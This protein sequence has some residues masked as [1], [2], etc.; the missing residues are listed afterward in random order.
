MEREKSIRERALPAPLS[1][2]DTSALRSLVLAVTS[3]SMAK[4]LLGLGF[5]AGLDVGSAGHTML[6]RLGPGCFSANSAAVRGLA[7]TAGR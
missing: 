7:G 4:T 6:M 2:A 5:Q 3:H 1:A